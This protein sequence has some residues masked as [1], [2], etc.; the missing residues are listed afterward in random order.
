MFPN[1]MAVSSPTM[2]ANVYEW[3][4][5]DKWH[6]RLGHPSIKIVHNLVRHFSLPLYPNKNSSLCTSCSV[7]KS[8]QQLFGTISFQSHFPL[9]EEM[10]ERE[11]R[12]S[13]W[14]E[15]LEWE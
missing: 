13:E 8:H 11:E 12:E 6:K 3:T 5:L 10:G 2:V 9:R 7:N 14:R 1:S 15:K 4:S